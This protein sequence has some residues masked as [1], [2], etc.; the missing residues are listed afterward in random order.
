M[1]GLEHTLCASGHDVASKSSKVWTKMQN[2]I[3]LLMKIKM[4]HYNIVHKK[5]SKILLQPNTHD[6]PL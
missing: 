3:I 1:K 4:M 5:L 6:F 2:A